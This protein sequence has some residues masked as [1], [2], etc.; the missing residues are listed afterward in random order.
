MQYK[1]PR[2]KR[3]TVQS[4]LDTVEAKLADNSL[5]EDSAKDKL[6]ALLVEQGDLKI[7]LEQLEMDW[8]EASEALQ[9]AENN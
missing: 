2:K 3:E 1:N 7:E 4:K 6:K 8:F 9:D 5:Y